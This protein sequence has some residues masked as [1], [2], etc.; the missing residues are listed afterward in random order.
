MCCKICL[1]DFFCKRESAVTPTIIFLRAIHAP[2]ERRIL[3]P[4]WRWSKVP[5]RATTSYRGGCCDE[6]CERGSLGLIGEEGW[7]VSVVGRKD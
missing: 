1:F 5:P 3:W 4:G 6:N 7:F 2:R